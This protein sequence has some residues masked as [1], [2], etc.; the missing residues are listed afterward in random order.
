VGVS[1]IPGNNRWFW[2]FEKS[3][4]KNHRFQ[5]F[6]RPQRTNQASRKNRERTGGFKAVI[7][8]K[9]SENCGHVE[10]PGI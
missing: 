7:F 9:K 10:Y 4:P 1:L 6:Q 8:P 2:E 3:E 5:E